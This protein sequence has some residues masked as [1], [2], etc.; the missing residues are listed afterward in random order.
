MTFTGNG[1]VSDT[2]MNMDQGGQKM[3][4]KQHMEGKYLGALHLT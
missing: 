4:M 1:Y 3:N 2:T